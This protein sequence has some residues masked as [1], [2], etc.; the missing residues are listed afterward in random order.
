MKSKIEQGAENRESVWKATSKVPKSTDE[1]VEATGLAKATA[2]RHLRKM[3]Q[4]KK[5]TQ[6]VGAYDKRVA[7]YAR[8]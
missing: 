5:L 1:I 3:V 6:F 7:T 8:D 4:E 2:A